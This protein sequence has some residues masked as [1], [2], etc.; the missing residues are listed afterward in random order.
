M[1]LT[2]IIFQNLFFFSFKA[3]VAIGNGKNVMEK[4]L[5]EI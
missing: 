2:L 4:N 3:L 1:F 5:R